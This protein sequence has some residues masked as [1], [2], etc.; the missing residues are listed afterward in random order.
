[1][2]RAERS[3]ARRIGAKHYF[4]GVPCSRG[5]I[6]NRHTSNGVCVVCRL[7]NV[8]KRRETERGKQESRLAARQW[9]LKNRYKEEV[10]LRAAKRAREWRAK[11]RKKPEVRKKALDRQ[12][13]WSRTAR[14]RQSRSAYQKRVN[15]RIT[16]NIRI[17]LYCAVKRNTIG[18]SAVRSLGCSID[19]LKAH[20]ETL[21][22][23]GM[24]WENYGNWHIDH[25]RPLSSFNLSDATQFDEAFHYSN[26]QPLWAIDNCR[27]GAKVQECSRPSLSSNSMCH[28][29]P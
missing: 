15:V 9:H 14:G 11:N 22:A 6:A 26:L 12:I 28:T 17:R 24:C 2:K 25:I 4:T 10:R 1:M 29:A 19:H 21:F 23:P 18:A 5:H 3:R 8:Q 7:E 13:R 27:K 20:L 16:R